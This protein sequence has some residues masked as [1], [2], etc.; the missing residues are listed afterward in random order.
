M[1]NLVLWKRR[2]GSEV[3][4]VARPNGA[5]DVPPMWDEVWIAADTRVTDPSKI[6][7]QATK[8]FELTAV[9]HKAIG[10]EGFQGYWNL[11]MCYAFTGAVFPAIMAHRALE[12]LLGKLAPG[13]TRL[14]TLNAVAN[15]VAWIVEK[16]VREASNAFAKVPHC[17]V[18]LVGMSEFE[19]NQA[20]MLVHPAP[21]HPDFRYEARMLP[22]HQVHVFGDDAAALKKEIDRLTASGIPGANGMEP[23]MALEARIQAG[24]HRTVGGTVQFGV[25]TGNGIDIYG[26]QGNTDSFLGFD[27]E[28]IAKQIGFDILLDVVKKPGGGALIERSKSA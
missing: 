9:T 4:P 1:T 3:N 28:S 2:P 6:S 7:D 10:E 8:I 25:H 11:R 5:R 15:L 20:A 22:L 14:P 17:Q 23:K 19:G 16:Y 24:K 21:H 27:L 13:P 12:V 26:L 18:V